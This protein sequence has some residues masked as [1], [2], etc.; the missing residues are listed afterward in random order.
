VAAR[1]APERV[2][3]GVSLV[4]RRDRDVRK[5]FG[6]GGGKDPYELINELIEKT[7]AGSRG[8]VFL[9]YLAASAAPRWNPHARGT[10]TGLTFAHDRGC[11][12]RAFIEGITMEMKDILNS[13]VSS[14]I[15]IGKVRIMGGAT[16]SALWN[17]IQSDMYDRPVE[18][19]KVT[20]AALLGAAIFAG[21]GS[22][23]FGD[24]REGVAKMVAVDKTYEPKRENASLYDELYG[25]YCGVYEGLEGKRVFQR[26]AK[27]QERY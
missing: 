6:E 7:P 11:L 3:G 5:A 16:K 13:M 21:V 25:I 22:G 12:A 18:T 4:P 17:Q 1:G 23:H 26:L 19:L 14:G 8:L 20:D 10:F 24:I 9:P 2:R 27:V 15:E